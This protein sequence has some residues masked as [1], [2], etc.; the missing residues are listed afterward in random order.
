V[1]QVRVLHLDANLGAG[2]FG[3]S[4]PSSPTLDLS[5]STQIQSPP[6]RSH[7]KHCESAAHV[8]QTDRKQAIHCAIS[9]VGL[10]AITTNQR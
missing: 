3:A 1:P 6:L 2:I 4:V 9:E 8:F 5:P 10:A 7:E